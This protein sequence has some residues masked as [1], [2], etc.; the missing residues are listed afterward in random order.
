[1][2]R[3]P[4]TVQHQDWHSLLEDSLISLTKWLPAFWLLTSAKNGISSCELGRSLSVTQKSAWFMPHRIRHILATCSF[5]KMNGAVEGDETYIGG[6]ERNK[7]SDKK[8]Q[9]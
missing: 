2:L 6:L 7:H 1:V 8:A 9:G 4:E 5:E 3:L